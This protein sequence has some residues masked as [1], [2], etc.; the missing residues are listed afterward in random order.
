[1]AK[2]QKISKIALNFLKVFKIL[3][4]LIL[5]LGIAVPIFFLLLPEFDSPTSLLFGD[6]QLMLSQRVH[7]EIPPLFCISILLVSVLDAAAAIRI[8]FHLQ[9]ILKPM[10]EGRPFQAQ[11]AP[12]IR[13]IG[14][15]YMISDFLTQ[16]T[17][18]AVS[19]FTFRQLG[20]SQLLVNSSISGVSLDLQFHCNFLVVFGILLLLS[21][22]F[23]YGQELQ[24]LSDETI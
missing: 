3:A 17:G 16:V 19:A 24:Q 23:E 11:I 6:L 9:N 12:S 2:L 18:C 13:K 1:M 10:A 4:I 21:Y 7:L 20:I 22:V 5:I 8:I 15:L 14:W